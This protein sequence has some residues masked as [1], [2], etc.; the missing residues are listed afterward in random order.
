MA[1]LSAHHSVICLLVFESI[2]SGAIL[3]QHVQFFFIHS[4]ID[5]VPFDDPC[6]RK[7]IIDVFQK[8]FLNF[9]HLYL[10]NYY[11]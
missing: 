2:L 8:E 11:L 7:K 1:I 10:L 5:F 4:S 9:I 6:L 3:A